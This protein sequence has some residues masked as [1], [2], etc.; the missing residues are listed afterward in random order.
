[1]RHDQ[2]LREMARSIQ[3]RLAENSK[4]NQ[5]ITTGIKFIKGGDKKTKTETSKYAN[6]L[7]SAKGAYQLT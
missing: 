2:V 5:A 7:T 6:Y 3:K 1:M 4:Q